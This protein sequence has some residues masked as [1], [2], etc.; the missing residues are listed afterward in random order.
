M[1]P[2]C[3]NVTCRSDQYQCK[4]LT[5]IAGHFLCSGKAE[6]KD[7]S[8]EINCCKYLINPLY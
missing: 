1:E 4:D 8:D 5:C 3:Q 7:G 6:C 2:N